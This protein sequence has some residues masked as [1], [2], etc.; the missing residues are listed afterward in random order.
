MIGL[1]EC[2]VK[3]HY[4]LYIHGNC[5]LDVLE[6]LRTCKEPALGQVSSRCGGRLSERQRTDLCYPLLLIIMVEDCAPVLRAHVVAL[7]VR[8]CWVMDPVEVLHLDKHIHQVNTS[9]ILASQRLR[10]PRAFAYR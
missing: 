10:W 6:Y 4:A 3:C 7:S 1:L 8:C 2:N 9:A 5:N